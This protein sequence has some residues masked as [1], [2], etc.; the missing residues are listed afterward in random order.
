[1]PTKVTSN[2]HTRRFLDGSE[3]PE[4]V[5]EYYD[6][7]SEDD[8][9][10]GWILYRGDYMHETDFMSLHHPWGGGPGVSPDSPLHEWDGYTCDSIGCG[11]ILKYVDDG[12]DRGYRI[13]YYV[14]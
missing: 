5:H 7:L 13:G 14:S 6:W 3:V 12:M 11:T 4:K 9:A 8:R 1:M 10:D 2:R